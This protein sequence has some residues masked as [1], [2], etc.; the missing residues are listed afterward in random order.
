[1]E[2]D[3]E[4][5]NMVTEE[6][7]TKNSWSH[8]TLSKQENDRLISVISQWRQTNEAFNKQHP[9]LKEVVLNRK[10]S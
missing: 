8:P 10:T 7:Y 4:L 9:E 3:E 1:M 2:C 5:A 6:A